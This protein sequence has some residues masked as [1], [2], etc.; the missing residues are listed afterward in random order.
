LELYPRII[1]TCEIS[2]TPLADPAVVCA[3]VRSFE[4]P[5]HGE[6]EPQAQTLKLAYRRWS[7]I[8]NECRADPFRARPADDADGGVES[9]DD[10]LVGNDELSFFIDKVGLAPRVGSS[11]HISIQFPPPAE[12]TAV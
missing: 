6:H 10:A 2:H 8:A 1:L 11:P 12:S 9:D 7:Q 5:R 3:P 4:S